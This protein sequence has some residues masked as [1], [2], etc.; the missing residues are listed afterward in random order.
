M[1]TARVL[2]VLVMATVIAACVASTGAPEEKQLA[3]RMTYPGS[4]ITIAPPDGTTTARTKS[5]DAYALCQQGVADCPTSAP[6]NVELVLATDT[7]SGTLNAAGGVNPIMNNR[8]VWVI[9]WVGIACSPH[10]G[11]KV[12]TT[13]DASP[14]SQLCDTA[15]FV[16]AGSG[17]YI[18]TYTGP[19]S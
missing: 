5:A 19:H 8:L 4:T 7:G 1:N 18:F 6:A 11:A 3:T 9:N 10:G 15:A 2:V 12:L 14:A 16:D 13:P 17:A